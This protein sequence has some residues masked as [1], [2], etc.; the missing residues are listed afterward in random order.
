MERERLAAL[1]EA[2]GLM[3]HEVRNPVG[4]IM[5]AVALLKR[6]GNPSPADAG[7]LSIILL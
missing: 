1:G 4:S 6:D 7:L 5:N 2:A 3:A